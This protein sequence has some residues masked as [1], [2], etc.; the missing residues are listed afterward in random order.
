MPSLL[1]GSSIVADSGHKEAVD[2]RTAGTLVA[3]TLAVGSRVAGN[4][5]VVDNPLVVD[6]RPVVGIHPVD[7]VGRCRD[8][9]GSFVVGYSR[10]SRRIG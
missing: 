9:L 2:S 10:H 5:R 8:R 1:P 7:Q 4:L 6:S 3:G